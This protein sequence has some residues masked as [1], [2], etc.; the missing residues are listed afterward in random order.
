MSRK[1]EQFDLFILHVFFIQKVVD[2][3]VHH[4]ELKTA[5][6]EYQMLTSQGPG[7]AFA[8]A[9]KIVEILDGSSKVKKIREEM[10]L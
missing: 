8:F 9:L 6:G 10:L 3:P 5:D 1:T 2:Q 4:F 7:T